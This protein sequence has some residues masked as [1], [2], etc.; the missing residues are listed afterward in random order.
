MSESI[1]IS[2]LQTKRAAA[3]SDDWVR[4]GAEICAMGD[5]VADC[6]YGTI[7]S[8]SIWQRCVADADCIAAEHNASPALAAIALA[9]L[10]FRDAMLVHRDAAH[11]LTDVNGSLAA[12]RDARARGIEAQRRLFEACKAVRR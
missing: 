1:S 9:A 2:E 11:A 7:P 3:A 8:E 5:D 10:D 6:A 4:R 12:V